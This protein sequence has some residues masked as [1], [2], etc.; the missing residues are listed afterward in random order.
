MI[1]PYDC[2][3]YFNQS[4]RTASDSSNDFQT[5]LISLMQAKAIYYVLTGVNLNITFNEY[6]NALDY[7]I[8][9]IGFSQLEVD[10][11]TGDRVVSP[12]RRFLNI[13]IK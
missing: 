7:K 8:D 4:L 1:S 6:F 11:R 9:N 12:I 13:F 3:R 5:R 2:V 10:N